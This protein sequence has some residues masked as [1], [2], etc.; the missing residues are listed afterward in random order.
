MLSVTRTRTLSFH[1]NNKRLWLTPKFVADAGLSGDDVIYQTYHKTA[2]GPA[3]HIHREPVPESIKCKVANTAKGGVID[4]N[5]SDLTEHFQDYEQVNIT[6]NGD[7]IVITGAIHESKVIERETALRRRAKN[8]GPIR[9]GGIFVGTGLLCESI[10]QGMAISGVITK[11]RFGAELAELPA[12]V[13][14]NTNKLWND[15]YKDARFYQGDIHHINL[16]IVPKLDMLV[17]GF[18]CPASSKLNTQRKVKGEKDVFHPETGTVFQPTLSIIIKSN[19]ALVVLENVVGFSGS[20]V[21]HIMCDVMRRQGYLMTQT[22]L[23]GT[24][25][26]DFERR[27]RL[28]RVW[29]SKNL[30]EPDLLQ[31]KEFEQANAL[32]VG[33]VIEPISNDDPRWGRRKYL[34]DKHIEKKNNHKYCLVNNKTTLLNTMGANYGK[35]QPDSPMIPHPEKPFF[36][37]IFTQAEHC[38]IRGIN[39]QMKK[40]IVDL[41]EGKSDLTINTHTKGFEAHKMLG[42]SCSPKPWISSG[43]VFGQWV[44][45]LAPNTKKKRQTNQEEGQMALVGV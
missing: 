13:N 36:S 17:I 21:D 38:N 9:K 37:R 26:G 35:I 6:V 7:I 18:P 16:N 22:Y 31:I 33:D 34:E 40:A 24:S 43:R 44:K 20:E 4:I 32:T 39:G 3:L 14:I 12:E 28:C 45:S 5:R 11:E 23:T 29:Y 27:Q 41:A 2:D 1:R 42:N 8:N 10:H 15:C 25:H 19:P 30:P